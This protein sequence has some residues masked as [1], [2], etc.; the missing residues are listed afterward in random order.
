MRVRIL[1]L[2]SFSLFVLAALWT[3]AHTIAYTTPTIM[4]TVSPTAPVIVFSANG[5]P[6]EMYSDLY[7]VYRLYLNTDLNHPLTDRDRHYRQPR[8]SPDGRHIVYTVT[9]I[10]EDTSSRESKIEIM[11]ANGSNIQGLTAGNGEFAPTWS[12][13]GETIAYASHSD[14]AIYLMD[15]NGSN[16]RMIRDGVE[17]SSLDFSPD[18][19]ELVVAARLGDDELFQPYILSVDGETLHPLLD[20]EIYIWDAAWSPDGETIALATSSEGIM[21]TDVNGQTREPLRFNGLWSFITDN[22]VYHVSDLA[23]S[24]DGTQLA[25]ILQ[26]HELQKAVSTPVPY[27]RVGPQLAIVDLDSSELRLLTYGFSNN[28]PDWRP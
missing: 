13:N 2:F 1:L 7:G 19:E 27:E 16:Q 21:L 18:G 20:E 10:M 3:T 17:V 14:N 24:P 11:D 9:E 23:W 28:S 26:S 8:W 5:Q 15:A 22:N 25:F 12:P 4:P 6:S